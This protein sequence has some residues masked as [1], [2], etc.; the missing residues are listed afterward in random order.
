MPKRHR[1]L[2][3][4]LAPALAVL[5]L[6]ACGG[7]G[8][9][10]S[11]AVASIDGAKGDSSA[12]DGNGK[13]KDLTEAE[14]EDVMVEFS[15]CIR[16]HGVELSDPKTTGVGGDRSVVIAGPR[17]GGTT[18]G[19]GGAI[20]TPGGVATFS[21]SDMQEFEAAQKECQPILTD[22][23]GEPNDISP[24][25]QAEMQDHAIAFAKCMRD[26]GIDMPD[27]TFEGGS[28]G[29]MAT[30]QELGNGIDPSSQEF[31]HA[32]EACQSKLG[33]DVGGRIGGPGG[34]GGGPIT[35]S[36]RSAATDSAAS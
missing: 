23:F 6:A 20:A 33:D 2:T 15:T 30:T 14:R 3:S 4:A 26:N 11:D 34:A 12:D 27:P 16:D 18:S 5:L 17:P 13:G 10:A 36:N 22:A 32:E 28:R 1:I 35:R 8:A 24:E 21:G 9:A 31:Q 29:G 25:E 7:G 19:A